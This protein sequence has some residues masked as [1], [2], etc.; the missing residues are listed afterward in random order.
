MSDKT[1]S[2]LSILSEYSPLSTA[3]AEQFVRYYELLLEKNSVMNLTRITE[4]D[5]VVEKHFADSLALAKYKDLT[6]PLRIL[7]LGCG[8]GFPGI[9]LKIAF[10]AL[11]V[12]L[13]D[14][15][16]K[17]ISFV[18]DVIRELQLND[19]VGIHARAEDLARKNDF[20]EQFDLVTSRA[21]ANLSTL[22]EYCLPFVRKGGSF[23]AYKSGESDEEI[24]N[25]AHAISVCGGAAPET[26]RYSLGDMGRSLVF[27]SKEKSTPRVYPRKA[28]TPSK[29]PL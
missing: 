25:A 17:K 20:R 1:D 5:D 8:A 6:G 27:I 16:G 12:T 19:C 7:D 4:F 13:L 14:S 11:Q 18:N 22:S 29:T 21:V 2:I 23:I 28:G 10:P 24:Q 26:I 15:V 9:P 3:Q